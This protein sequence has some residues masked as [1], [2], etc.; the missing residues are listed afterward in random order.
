MNAEMLN[1]IMNFLSEIDIVVLSCVIGAFF[2]FIS[3]GGRIS[4]WKFG[5]I[6]KRSASLRG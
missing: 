3:I 1:S 6:N 5:N 4:R 2:L